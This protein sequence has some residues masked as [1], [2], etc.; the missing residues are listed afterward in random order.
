MPHF[1]DKGFW[2]MEVACRRESEE[3]TI[4]VICSLLSKCK[5]CLKKK[6]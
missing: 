6:T 1:E 3:G 4:N 2:N 5:T